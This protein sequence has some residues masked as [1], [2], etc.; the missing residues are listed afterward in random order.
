MPEPVY[1][2]APKIKALQSLANDIPDARIELIAEV[3]VDNVKA[4]LGLETY[5]SL[6]G[7]KRLEYAICAFAIAKLIVSSREISEGNSIHSSRGWGEGDIH[8]SE[9]SEMVKLSKHWENQGNL[10]INQLKTEI[11]AEIGWVDI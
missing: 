3:C 9:V 8:P 1:V 10:T 7:D 4:S 5:I 11:P 2:W 6:S